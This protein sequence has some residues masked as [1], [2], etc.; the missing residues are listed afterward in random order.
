MNQNG[1]IEKIT[2]VLQKNDLVKGVWL[3]GSFGRG[4]ADGFSDIDVVVLVDDDKVEFVFST[5]QHKT[6]DISPVLFSKVLQPSKTINVITPE[7]LRFDLTFVSKPQLVKM[8]GSNLKVLFDADGISSSIPALQEMQSSMKPEALTDIANEFLRVIGLMP[9]VMGR[10]ELAVGQTGSNFLR[11][12]LIKI[13]VHE[14]DPQLV[15]GALSLSRSLK[16]DQMEILKSLPPIAAEKDA[17]MRV[18]KVIAENFLPRARGLAKRIGAVWP[19]E[20]EQGTLKH[21]RDKLGLDIVD[22]NDSGG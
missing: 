4:D 17:I 8:S 1:L 20:F 9:V 21:L 7:W 22:A 13:M 18:N 19:E 5:F 2:Q 3:A 14:N 11:E 10:G 15:R 16:K 6:G 12:M